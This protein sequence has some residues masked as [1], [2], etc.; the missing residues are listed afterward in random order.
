MPAVFAAGL[1]PVRGGSYAWLQPDGGWGLSNSGL[2]VG[3]GESLL[4]DTLFDLPHTRRMLAGLAA[5]TAAAPTTTV[6]N[7]HGNGD[8]WF[9]NAL[10]GD[11]DIVAAAASVED[12]KA[13]GPQSLRALLALGGPTGDYLRRIFGRY[14]F[15]GVRPVYPTCTFERRL[16]LCVG[17]VDVLL[18]DVG[19]AHTRG[20]TIVYCPRDGVVFTGDIVFADGTPIVWAGPVGNWL[21]ACERILE[22]RPA[23]IVPGHGP[24]S[25]RSA[26]RRMADYLEF[27]QSEA[28]KRHAAGMSAREAA[29]DIDLGPFAGRP[30]SERLAV[31]VQ[32]IYRELEPAGAA[33]P[34]GPELFGC[35]ADLQRHWTRGV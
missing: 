13:V 34:T 32:A 23:S 24:V 25:D 15:D 16:E 26:V 6:V 8:H 35:M 31:N 5:L 22:L 1:S 2:I 27:V 7:T 21:A 17:G 29:F 9:G 18:I 3:D 28:S 30:E 10:M 33:Q 12:M 11:A 20:D 19:P 14:Q 4:V